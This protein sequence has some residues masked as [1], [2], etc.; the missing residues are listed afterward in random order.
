M[1]LRRL[2]Q[3]RALDAY[4]QVLD[5]LPGNCLQV[6]DA[7][8]GKARAFNQLGITAEAEA[9]FKA[10]LQEGEGEAD[11]LPGVGGA[12]RRR[13]AMEA[14][15]ALAALAMT[16]G[17]AHEAVLRYTEAVEATEQEMASS[18]SSDQ[19]DV[20]GIEE[21]GYTLRT[22]RCHRAAAL[23]AV[24]DYDGALQDCD[25]VLRE[26]VAA[27]ADALLVAFIT[28]AQCRAANGEW[29]R[30]TEDYTAYLDATRQADAEA[31]LDPSPEAAAR[32]R[33]RAQVFLKR[34]ESLVGMALALTVSDSNRT[35][36]QSLY[37]A[38]LTDLEHC[39]ATCSDL[40]LVAAAS[41]MRKSIRG[42]EG[43]IIRN[44]I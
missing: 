5:I 15:A 38:A 41:E 4:N 30:A 26:Q 13:G 9:A 34:S 44:G 23:L 11:G 16:D 24:A 43:D 40:D 39:E 20:D 35:E 27:N 29:G 7:W 18:G 28:R 12:W 32:R 36:L 19:P 25:A 37:T 33:Q 10:S 3:R 6:Q 17:R 42:D 21:L 22:L 31:S 2:Q 1:S 8:L 14:H